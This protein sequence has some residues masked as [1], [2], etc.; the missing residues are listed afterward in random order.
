VNENKKLTQ[1]FIKR[2]NSLTFDRELERS[3]KLWSFDKIRK[4]KLTTSNNN[5]ITH[6]KERFYLHHRKEYIIRYFQITL[7]SKQQVVSEKEI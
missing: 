6:L 3:E 4:L 7:V 2:R 5:G 1:S